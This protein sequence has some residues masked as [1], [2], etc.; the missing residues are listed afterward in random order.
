MKVIKTPITILIEELKNDVFF[1]K[2]KSAITAFNTAIEKATAKLPE[3]KKHIF[4]AYSTGTVDG[5]DYIQDISKFD[6]TPNPENYFDKTYN[7]QP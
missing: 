2:S 7:P 5:G 3:E 1:A 4:A 6:E